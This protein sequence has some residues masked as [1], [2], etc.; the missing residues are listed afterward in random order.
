MLIA[1]LLGQLT[2]S[3]FFKIFLIKDDYHWFLHVCYFKYGMILKEKENIIILNI[4]ISQKF[5]KPA[6]K[7]VE[8]PFLKNLM[9]TYLGYKW[10]AHHM[11]TR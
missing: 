3:A 8:L 11:I 2:G 5:R 1:D 6:Q 4:E 7:R 10:V 9:P